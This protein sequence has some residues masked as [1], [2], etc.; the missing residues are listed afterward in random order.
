MFLSITASPS[1]TVAP[2]RE[3][4]AQHSSIVGWR[5][6]KVRESWR[7]IERRAA[8]E[9]ALPSAQELFH[10]PAASAQIGATEHVLGRSFT[11]T[12]HASLRVHDGQIET[13]HV[14]FQWLPNEM[15]LLTLRQTVALWREERAFEI[16]PAASMKRRRAPKRPTGSVT[17]RP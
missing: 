4:G 8:S 9:P 12:Y 3:D 15:D 17:S 10:P 14:P 11:A 5:M 2:Y 16:R 13:G 1:R 7:R 6:D